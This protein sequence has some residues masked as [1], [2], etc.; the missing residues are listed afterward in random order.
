MGM[1]INYNESDYFPARYGNYTPTYVRG[2]DP[3]LIRCR[4]YL[5]EKNTSTSMSEL[6]YIPLS[7]CIRYYM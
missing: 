1:G 3:I 5:A 4:D 7:I 2:Q 6:Y